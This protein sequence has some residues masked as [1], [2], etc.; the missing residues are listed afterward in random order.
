MMVS[1]TVDFYLYHFSPLLGIQLGQHLFFGCGDG[2]FIGI[3]CE[4]FEIL[5]AALFKHKG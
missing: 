3:H 2:S 1:Q 4:R 5:L